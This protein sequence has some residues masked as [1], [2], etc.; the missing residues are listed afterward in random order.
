MNPMSSGKDEKRLIDFV[1]SLPPNVNPWN[2]V[3]IY[4]QNE[5]KPVLLPK[6]A[7]IVMAVIMLGYFVMFLQCLH[8]IYIRLVT[9]TFRIFSATSLGILKI[10]IPNLTCLIYFVFTLLALTDLTLQQLIDAAYLPHMMGKLTLFSTKL[11]ILL[12]GS[13]GFIWVCIC[14]CI[15]TLW[16]EKWSKEVQSRKR[17]SIPTFWRQFLSVVFLL[18]AI[19]PI[20]GVFITYYLADVQFQKLLKLETSILSHLRF[21]ASTHDSTNYRPMDLMLD[22]IP[23][24][25]LVV[26]RDRIAQLFRLGIIFGLSGLTFLGIIYLPVLIISLGS[27]RRRTTE[28]TFTAATLTEDQYEQFG[29][30]RARLKEEHRAVT[31]HAAFVYLFT[32]MFIPVMS[33]QL[34]YKDSTFLRDKKWLIVTQIGLHGPFAIGGNCIEFILNRQ[35]RRLL[36]TY[37]A[38]NVACRPTGVGPTEMIPTRE[39]KSNSTNSLDSDSCNSTS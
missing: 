28:A 10:D 14:Q 8:L 6:W 33:W 27:L 31:T 25:Q 9:K 23:A 39:F 2:A 22:L 16:E 7:R 35:A 3:A 15:L 12:A 36:S 17:F 20:V 24:R 11:A 18:I 5:T 32:I 19:W 30:I 34:T 13:W 4:L 29:R 38:N 1:T 26:Y 37:R 21:Q